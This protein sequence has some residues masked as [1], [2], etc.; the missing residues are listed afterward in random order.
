VS[1]ATFLNIESQYFFAIYQANALHMSPINFLLRTVSDAKDH[2]LVSV[3]GSSLL[4]VF[5]A[6]SLLSDL[7]DLG[8][9]LFSLEDL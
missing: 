8:L 3:F 1:N 6:S 7:G 2:S 5:E 9:G 4:A